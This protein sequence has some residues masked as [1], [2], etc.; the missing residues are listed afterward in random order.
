MKNALFWEEMLVN[1]DPIEE[2]EED[3]QMG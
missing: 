1:S 2:D 3:N